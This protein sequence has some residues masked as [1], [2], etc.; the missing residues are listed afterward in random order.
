MSAHFHGSGPRSGA[1]SVSK[2]SRWARYDPFS[3]E[4]NAVYW[5]FNGMLS[6]HPAFP[7]IV[8]LRP[9]LAEFFHAVTK[10]QVK[11][12]LAAM[13]AEYLEDL[14]AVFLLPGTMKQIRSWYCTSGCVG[15]YWRRCVFL[16]ASRY[17][18]G[19][20]YV[21]DL[22]EFFL[23]DV[24]VHEIAHHNDHRRVDRATREGFANAFVQQKRA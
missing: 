1:G 8:V 24:L 12:R 16:F 3:A 2:L 6:H 9:T 10:A 17:H 14:R 20:T 11:R 15:M 13:P 19:Y 18:H 22:R 7:H 4:V 21:D 23:N 5:R